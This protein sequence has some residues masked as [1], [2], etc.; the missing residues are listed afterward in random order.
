[1]K[2]EEDTA[3]F[4]ELWNRN[5]VVLYRKCL[6]LMGDVEDALAIETWDEAITILQAIRSANSSYEEARIASL[7]CDAYVGRGLQTLAGIRD[8]SQDEEEL[9]SQALADFEARF[10]QGE[11]PENMREVE[12]RADVQPLAI[13]Q[14][15][16][17]AG[18]TN[19]TSEAMRM[20]EQGGVRIDGEKVADKNLK[21]ARGKTVVLQVGKR[22]F[23]RITV[24]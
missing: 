22:K 6:A 21:L 8:K 23:A 12:I 20:I 18:L 2:Q 3:G 10:K 4:W 5:R 17:E 24:S 19:S 11:L 9:V 1:M 15:V 14:V 16:K 7:F 13:Y